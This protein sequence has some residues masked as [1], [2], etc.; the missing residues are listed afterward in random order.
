MPV[1]SSLVGC[2]SEAVTIEV[3]PRWSMAYAAALDDSTK[4]Y[5]DTRDKSAFIA[6]PMFP[7]C[8]E[9]PV[10][11]AMRRQM[12]SAGL[13][14]AEA[15][16]GVHASHDLMIHRAIRPPEK[17]STVAEIVSAERRSAGAYIVTRLDTIDEG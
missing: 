17:L 8:F 10:I 5:F 7:V 6:H 14:F 2:R 15:I 13:K 4:R 1:T 11:V 3:T 9:W 16:R 12:E